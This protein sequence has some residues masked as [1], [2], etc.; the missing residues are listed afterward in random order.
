MSFS[1]RLLTALP[2]LVAS[3]GCHAIV[4]YGVAKNDTRDSA[5]GEAVDLSPADAESADLPGADL[6]WSDAPLADL[7][8][9][10]APVLDLALPDVPVPD[11]PLPDAP[12]PDLPLPDSG[13]SDG[14][15]ADGP[16]AC[17]VWSGW[18]CLT[19]APTIE[20]E[21]DCGEYSLRC[22]SGNGDC[23]CYE[24]VMVAG[25]C[26][27]MGGTTGCNRCETAF[28]KGCCF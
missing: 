27:G 22:Y 28:Q 21:A 23:T 17:G 19:I 10:D 26:S 25:I 16:A 9:P 4:P 7:P 11:Q 14:P 20:C 5:G 18:T 1:S 15:Q 8:L 6:P 2:L 13:T 24:G 12:V 3:A